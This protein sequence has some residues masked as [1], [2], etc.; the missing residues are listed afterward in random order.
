[1]SVTPTNQKKDDVKT[2]IKKLTDGASEVSEWDKLWN[3]LIHFLIN[4]K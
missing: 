4:L 1:M 3:I 2:N